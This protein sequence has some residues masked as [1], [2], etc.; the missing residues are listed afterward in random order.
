MKH[1]ELNQNI[2]QSFEH[3]SVYT[4]YNVESEFICI[5]PM[6]YCH[7]QSEMSNQ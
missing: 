5:A 1:D 7:S 2:A 4:V 3:V 6:K